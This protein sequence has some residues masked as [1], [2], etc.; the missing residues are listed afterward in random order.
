MTGLCENAMRQCLLESVRAWRAIESLFCSGEE[1]YLNWQK[2]TILR[3]LK[4]NI[5]AI[6]SIGCM[7]V[8]QWVRV[9]W[10]TFK[11]MGLSE[12]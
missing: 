4:C 12:A 10:G 7:L 2:G 9:S 11:K 1:L 5:C 3:G 8:L 6:F